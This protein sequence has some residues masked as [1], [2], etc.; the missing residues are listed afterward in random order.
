MQV[1]DVFHGSQHY[2]G[3]YHDL[4]LFQVVK[5]GKK[6][7]S[8]KR[9]ESKS[10]EKPIHHVCPSESSWSGQRRA[11]KPIKLVDKSERAKM[12]CLADYDDRNKD[13]YCADGGSGCSK[14]FHKVEPNEKG[15]FIY[16]ASGQHY[17]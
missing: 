10:M 16:T 1:G 9:I 13:V 5:L 7:A 17:G 2:G 11:R 15:M 8:L 14:N 6:F 3:S 12:V 4:G